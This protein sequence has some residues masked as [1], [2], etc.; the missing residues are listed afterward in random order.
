MISKKQ[1][2]EAAGLT[3]GLHQSK[4]VVLLAWTLDVAHDRA[5]GIARALLCEQLH[6]DL[7]DVTAGTGAAKNLDDDAELGLVSLL[8]NYFFR[9]G[10]LLVLLRWRGGGLLCHVASMWIGKGVTC[11]KDCWMVAEF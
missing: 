3:L 10:G 8:D 2:A 9:N 1:L 6:T 5:V 7:G 4:H 11:T